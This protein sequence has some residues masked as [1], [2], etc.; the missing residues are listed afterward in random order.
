MATENESEIHL[1]GVKKNYRNNGL[2]NLL[3]KYAVDTARC[4]GYSKTILWTQQNM[5]AAQK[6]YESTIHISL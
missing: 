1:L 6:L 2:G 5:K 4:K 3:I